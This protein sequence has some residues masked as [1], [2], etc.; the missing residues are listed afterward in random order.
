MNDSTDN[1][2]LDTATRIFRDLCEPAMINDAEKG[3]WSKAL[4][5]ALEESGVPFARN[6]GHIAVLVHGGEPAVALVTTPGL[7]IS[8][9]TSLAGEPQD[10]VSFDGAVPEAVQSIDLDQDRLVTFGAA[11]RLQQMAGALEK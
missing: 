9:A 1:I 8:Q 5:D 10:D 11:V 4:W 2:I 3:V 7:A 6:T